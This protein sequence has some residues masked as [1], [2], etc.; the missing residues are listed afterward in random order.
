MLTPKTP[1]KKV[2]IF[3]A[4]HD[5]YQTFEFVTPLNVPWIEV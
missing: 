1:V 2:L 5:I 3:S 4:V